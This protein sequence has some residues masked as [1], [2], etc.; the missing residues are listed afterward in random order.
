[1]GVKPGLL[2]SGRNIGFENMVLRNI[3]RSKR[4]EVNRRVEKTT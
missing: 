3:F 1:M 2:Y 4:D